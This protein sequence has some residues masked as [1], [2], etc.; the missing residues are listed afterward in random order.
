MGSGVSSLTRRGGKAAAG[1]SPQEIPAAVQQ[2]QSP[3]SYPIQ[4]GHPAEQY[5]LSSGS[6]S[7]Q[8][9]QRPILNEEAYRGNDDLTDRLLESGHVQETPA[10]EPLFTGRSN[11]SDGAAVAEM[12]AHTAMSLGMDN[13]DLLFNL[14]YFSE[15]EATTL[16][17][18]M[19]GVQQE[20]LA[21]HS[22]N[23]TPYKLKPAS[24]TAVKGLRGRIFGGDLVS[25][26]CECQVCKDIIEADSAVL[27]IPHCRHFFHEECLLRWSKLV[28]IH[29]PYLSIHQLPS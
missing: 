10:P 26:E 13:E 15:G 14:M 12:F 19:E 22:E 2:N 8:R 27:E 7:G 1:S 23:N 3:S 16:G 6:S 21:L 24:E 29:P 25:E 20:T 5:A 11:Q 4:M 18:V 9:L 28:S 17:A